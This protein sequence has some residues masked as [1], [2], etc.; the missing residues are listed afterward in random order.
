[1]KNN[2]NITLNILII[3]IPIIMVMYGID[4]KDIFEVDI[5]FTLIWILGS[6]GAIGLLLATIAIS[7]EKKRVPNKIKLIIVG[8]LLVTSTIVYMSFNGGFWGEKIISA[9]FLDDRSSMRLKLYK[10]GKYVLVSDWMFGDKRYIG[11][12]R[13]ETDTIYF[14]NYPLGDNDFVSKKLVLVNDS[15]YFRLLP[16]GQYDKH[17]YYFK[18]K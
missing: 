3:L 6:F 17:F 10:N 18:I 15:I 1:M 12:Y 4:M 16:D 9:T 11:N 7:L 5:L 14:D 2:S 8:L 13:I